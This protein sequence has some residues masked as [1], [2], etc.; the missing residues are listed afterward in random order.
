MGSLGVSIVAWVLAPA[1]LYGVA[2]GVGLALERLTTFRVTDGLLAPLGLCG[3]FV[4]VHFIY[5][6][7]LGSVPAAMLVVAVALAGYLAARGE[8]PGRAW[9]GTPAALGAVAAYALFMAPVVFAG[10]WTWTGYNFVNDT[11][12]QLLL[13]DHVAAH[14]MNA[15]A[16][17]AADPYSTATEHVRVYLSTGYPIGSHGLLDV[18]TR[19]TQIPLEAEYNP[20]IAALISFAVLSFAALGRRSGLRPAAAATIAF[21]A[22]AA[23]L[24]YQYALQGNIKEIAM[25]SALAA[26]VAV[27]R[28][29]LDARRPVAAAACLGVCAAAMLSVYS[30]AAV[31]YI[32]VIAVMV[33]IAAFVMPNSP[34]RAR[35]VPAAV[36]AL[37]LA[38]VLAIP[39]LTKIVRFGGTA[40]GVFASPS[41]ETELGHLLRP[42]ELVQ[43]A[44]VWLAGD[45]RIPVP[46]E[47][48]TLSGILIA[49]V[50]VLAALGLAWAIARREPGPLLYAGA[51]AVTLAVIAPRTSPYADAKMLALLSPGVVL[52]AGFGAAAAAWLWRPAAYA[53][54]AVALGAILWSDA[55]A[56][57]VVQLA[58]IKRMEAMED[59]ARHV[60]DD[61]RLALVTDAD[62]FAKYFMRSARINV[63]TEA[64]TPHQVELRIPQPFGARWFDIDEY[65]PDYVSRFA[66]VITRRSPSASRPP[67]DY[68]LT[69]RNDY[70]DVWRR[71][72]QPDVREH[73]GAYANDRATGVLPC[74][75]VRALARRARRNGDDLL[76]ARRTEEPELS[77]VALP[78]I[79]NWPDSPV[80]LGNVVPLTPGE[81]DGQ[82][83]VRGGRY[84]VW[85]RGSFGRDMHVYVDGREVGAVKG[86]NSPQQ[87]HELGELRLSRG[88]HA[89]RIE[90][91]GGRLA[92]G[93][94]FIGYVGPIAFQRLA[95]QPMERMRPSAAPSLCGT[96]VDW[97]E[98]V[99]ANP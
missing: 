96:R 28:E 59:A 91:R 56:Y 2:V 1:V 90:K 86:V 35:I 9:P 57:H 83:F 6:L 3:S 88:E 61:H 66:T 80:F 69:Y 4:L 76:V 37:G 30:A 22:V 32:G 58:P 60:P 89:V 47:R 87:W 68:A 97:I 21:A 43:T 49:L 93:D 5:R 94:G 81:V 24:V 13:A 92:P 36:V 64:I 67:S 85:L 34:L 19:L 78:R 52:L 70:Y 46:P 20:Y 82:T 54:A 7:G 27:A 38:A 53:V 33:L 55:Y 73:L 72:A 79:G 51:A 25:L 17:A 63:A 75:D 29:L 10:G 15:P 62:E 26:A 11:A 98:R 44:G 45:Y 40:R 8:L 84:R 65:R 50:L 95:A 48:H 74:S 39:A 71:R 16:G 31:P 12:V 14:G 99:R 18:V 23:N 77:P 41:S 42:L